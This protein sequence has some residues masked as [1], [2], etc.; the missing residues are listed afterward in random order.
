[1]IIYLTT[2]ISYPICCA[3][4]FSEHVTNF[5]WL[6][7]LEMVVDVLDDIGD[8]SGGRRETFYCI[9]DHKIVVLDEDVLNL[10]LEGKKNTTMESCCFNYEMLKVMDARGSP[11]L[12]D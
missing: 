2:N 5:P 9:D 6:E 10:G 1:M 3:V 7:L 11:V 4:C 12:D 8:L